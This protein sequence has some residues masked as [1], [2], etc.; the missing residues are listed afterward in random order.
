MVMPIFRALSR[1]Q[2]VVGASAFGSA[3][4]LALSKGGVASAAVV[5]DEPSWTL[6]SPM[7]TL[8]DA[9]QTPGILVGCAV[10]AARLRD[11]PDYAA[12]VRSQ[13]N[14]IV[15]DN[16]FKFGTLRPTIQ[17]FDFRDADTVADFAHSNGMKLRGHTLVW[18][19][20]MPAWFDQHV[21][22]A[23]AA[24]VLTSH[25]A[26]VCD[27]YAGQ[28]HSWDVVNEAVEVNDGR[29]DSLRNTPW[30]QLLG[31]GYID[32]AFQSARKADPRALLFYNE[33]GLEGE[34]AGSAAKRAAVLGLLHDLLKRGV[35]V[36]GVGIQSHIMAGHTYGPGLREFIQSAHQMG[37]RV[38]LTELDVND[39]ELA[40]T[41]SY[42]DSAVA[43]TYDRYLRAAL[44]D[45]YVSGVITWGITDRLTWLDKDKDAART[46]GAAQRPLP[47]D[48]QFSPK[49][50]FVAQRR[51]LKQ[52]PAVVP[53]LKRRTQ[54]L[55]ETAKA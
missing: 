48:A 44:A 42:R 45:G 16:A 13:A 53:V 37:L 41:T 15:G 28:I 10:D 11:M 20:Q 33:Y 1:R 52:A 38:M 43:T 17:A 29:P 18:H 2:F 8:K 30:L 24:A 4:V 49:P 54:L 31:P 26:A 51:A 22:A 12:L 25:I 21:T 55:V 34:D 35:P 6:D 27:R 50:A 9:G 5:G 14:I 32:T 47:F 46:D 39:R 19:K 3:A 40:L 36:D 23:N 7:V